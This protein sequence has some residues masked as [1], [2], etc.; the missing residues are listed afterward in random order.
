MSDADESPRAG[1]DEARNERASAAKPARVVRRR[2][3]REM[4]AEERAFI[5]R[6]AVDWPPHHDSDWG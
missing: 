1:A 5:A 2:S 3:P 6:Y 4:T